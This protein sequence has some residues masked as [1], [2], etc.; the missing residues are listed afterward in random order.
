MFIPFLPSMFPVAL[1]CP[2][3]LT[4]ACSVLPLHAG[5]AEGA[6]PGHTSVPRLMLGVAEA[7]QVGFALLSLGFEEE[8]ATR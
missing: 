2:A 4:S 3:H 6:F 5:P 7:A 8:I 1:P